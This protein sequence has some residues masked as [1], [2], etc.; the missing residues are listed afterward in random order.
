MRSLLKSIL[1]RKPGAD[2]P[3]SRA[4]FR[5]RVEALELREMPA[6][7]L[8]AGVLSIVGSDQADMARVTYDDRGTLNIRDDRIRV[9]LEQPGAASTAVYNLYR[10]VQ[11]Q[12]LVRWEQAVT[13]ITFTGG[14]GDD[15]FVN[16]TI[17]PA[18][19]DGGSGNDVLTGGTGSDVLT[20]GAGD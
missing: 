11:S 5:P 8:N 9:T 12:P 10:Q 19:A 15:T 20:G 17:L 18:E 13:R 14:A 3:T 4:P 7:A 1:N 16:N 2:R 6:I